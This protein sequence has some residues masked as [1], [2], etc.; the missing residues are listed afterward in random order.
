M[1]WKYSWHWESPEESSW[2]RHHSSR[3][4][5]SPPSEAFSS[6]ARAR[7]KDVN[8]QTTGILKSCG[9][10]H[11]KKKTHTHT[12]LVSRIWYIPNSIRTTRPPRKM[13]MNILQENTHG[14]TH[15]FRTM[16]EVVRLCLSWCPPG[17][18]VHCPEGCAHDPADEEEAHTV[19]TMT[20]HVQ[21]L[22]RTTNLMQP[23]CNDLGYTNHIC[24][25]WLIHWC[26]F[27]TCVPEKHFNSSLYPFHTSVDRLLHLLWSSGEAWREL[28]AALC[29]MTTCNL[30]VKA[31][32]SPSSPSSGSVMVTVWL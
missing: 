14:L 16:Q 29:E 24:F 1:L 2:C 13:Y 31:H 12:V 26:L 9:W 20:T 19:C 23:A 28:P 4:C 10:K 17:R 11:E 25:V 8:C 22:S 32:V 21:H 18:D 7:L 6:S 5:P 27:L 15:A 30:T 3:R